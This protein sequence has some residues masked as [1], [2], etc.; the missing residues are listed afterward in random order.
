MSKV[1]ILKRKL[2]LAEKEAACQVLMADEEVWVDYSDD[3]TEEKCLTCFMG[4][5][6]ESTEE[7]DRAKAKVC[8]I[9]LE[10]K[11]MKIMD[12][13]HN[14]IT[15]QKTIIFDRRKIIEQLE[16]DKSELISNIENVEQLY[17]NLY[18][19]KSSFNTQLGLLVQEISAREKQILERE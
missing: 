11:M 1:E 10:S 2:Y 3:E 9:N 17:N 13:L 4:Y 19:E 18:T 16:N 5:Q 6:S 12:G 14:Q 15:E 7:E 8:C